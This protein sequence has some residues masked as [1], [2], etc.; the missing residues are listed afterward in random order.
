MQ[1]FRILKISNLNET[2]TDRLLGTTWAKV[3]ALLRYRPVSIS[4]GKLMEFLTMLGQDVEVTVKP[5]GQ[6]GARHMSVSV[7]ANEAVKI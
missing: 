4:V 1:I 2:N 5:V 3:S 7:Q 6:Q